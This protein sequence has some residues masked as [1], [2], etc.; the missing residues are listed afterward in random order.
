MKNSKG[1]I[2]IVLQRFQEHR[3]LMMNMGYY[4][5]ASFI[6]MIINLFLSPLYALNLSAED[7]AIVGYFAS[8]QSL[9]GPLMLF[10]M[11]QNYMRE[12]YFRSERERTNLRSTMFK[13]FLVFPFIVMAISLIGLFIFLNASGA[14]HEMPFFPYA[15]LTFLPWALAGVYRLELIDCKVQRRARSYFKISITNSAILIV[16]TV[17]CVVAFKWGAT[18]KLIGALVPATAMFLWA[19]FRH[20]DTLKEKFDWTILKTAML[21]SA[22]LVLAAMLEFFA[23]GYDKVYL[24][25]YVQ[26]DQLG[27]YTIGLSIASYLSIFSTSMGETFNPDIYESIAHKDNRRAI[28]FVIIQLLMMAVIV[29]VF[30][31]LAKYAIYLLTAGRYVDSTPFA[32]IA[33]LAAVTGLVRGIVTPF[34]YSAKKTNVILFAKIFSS[35]AAILTYGVLIKNYGLYGAAWGYVICPLYNAAFA[36]LLYKLNIGFKR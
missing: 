3:K 6:P 4:L 10:E 36:L 23:G 32:Q 33:S 21:F 13:T 35:I 29:I 28:K 15:I 34:I 20:K 9:F 1:T 8:F 7:F 24:Q 31:L 5:M 2:E 11:H 22:P 25:R 14:G 30:I 27:I 18:G 19:F 12:Y 16:S 17:L 26:L